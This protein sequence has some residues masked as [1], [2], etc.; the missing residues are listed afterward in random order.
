[1]ISTQL[2]LVKWEGKNW[3]SVS[4]FCNKVGRELEY[5]AQ[6]LQLTRFLESPVHIPHSHYTLTPRK[7]LS[8]SG[9]PPSLSFDV[10]SNSHYY[11]FYNI[12]YQYF[13]G[14]SVDLQ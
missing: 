1:M 10:I 5:M 11:P 8:R 4:E 7:W 12:S 2:P 3:G 6:S 9:L 13:L 14:V